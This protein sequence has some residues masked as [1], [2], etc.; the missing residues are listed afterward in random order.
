V[1]ILHPT[2][3]QG[4]TILPCQPAINVQRGANIA[5]G[6]ADAL[7]S[8][9]TGS[10]RSATYT[11]QNTGSGVLTLGGTPNVTAGANVTAVSVTTPPALAINAGGS[12]TFVVEYT[13]TAPGAF[14]FGVSI[15]SDDPVNDP[16]TWA[17]TG[18]AN[19][20]G[21]NGDGGGED[22][23]GC[24]TGGQSGYWWLP[25]LVALAGLKLASTWRLWGLLRRSSAACRRPCSSRR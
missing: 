6:G 20:P 2:L 13:V 18:T 15:D 22:S 3:V 12:T 11:V 5:N 23:G 16:Y 17:A 8:G 10:I 4:L 24:S 21:G 9:S 25:A 14:D 19:A 1:R 7:G